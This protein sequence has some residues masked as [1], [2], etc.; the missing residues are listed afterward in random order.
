MPINHVCKSIFV[1]IKNLLNLTLPGER[2]IINQG[3]NIIH[4]QQ[5]VILQ[6]YCFS[7]PWWA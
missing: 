6:F 7:S 2:S 3:N 4:I 5:A 1:H